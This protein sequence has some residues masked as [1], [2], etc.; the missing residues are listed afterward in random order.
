MSINTLKESWEFL[1]KYLCSCLIVSKPTQ[2][3]HVI[4]ILASIRANALGIFFITYETN[5]IHIKWDNK[6]KLLHTYQNTFIN[7]V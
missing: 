4:I 3:G 5:V 2:F 1:Q 7:C 6:F